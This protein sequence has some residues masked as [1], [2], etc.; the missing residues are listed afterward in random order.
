MNSGTLTDNTSQSIDDSAVKPVV[1]FGVPVRN[2]EK[3]LPR[4]FDSLLAQDFEN[5]EVIIGDNLS[6]DRTE[7]ICR[8]YAHRDPRIK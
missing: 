3:Y 1:S 8:D 6:S 5:F 7:E 2:G 4:L